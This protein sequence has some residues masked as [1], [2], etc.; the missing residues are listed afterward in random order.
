MGKMLSLQ[1]KKTEGDPET[2]K[3]YKFTVKETPSSGERSHGACLRGAGPGPQG[4]LAPAAGSA[5]LGVPDQPFHTQPPLALQARIL[6]HFGLLLQ[7]IPEA[8]PVK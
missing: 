2:F 4:P 1:K 7:Y 3:L 5:A 8:A 6:P